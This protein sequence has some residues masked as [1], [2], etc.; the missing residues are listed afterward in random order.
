MNEAGARREERGEKE[1]GQPVFHLL[2]VPTFSSV[3]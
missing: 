2:F 3:S 1:L